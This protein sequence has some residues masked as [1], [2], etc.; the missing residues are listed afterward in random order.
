LVALPGW[1][2]KETE[3]KRN[4]C[5]NNNRK[6]KTLAKGRQGRKKRKRGG[7]NRKKGESP[8]ET[9]VATGD[10]TALRKTFGRVSG[11]TKVRKHKKRNLDQTRNQLG[12]R[13]GQAKVTEKRG[14]RRICGT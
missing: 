9:R 11:V 6:K 4:S 12:E 5:N 13:Q 14:A 2:E 3:T 7:K 1:R 10:A 8:F